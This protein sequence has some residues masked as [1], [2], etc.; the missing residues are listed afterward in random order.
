MLR[1][2]LWLLLGAV[3]GF[4]LARRQAG[5][6]EAAPLAEDPALELRRKLEE[7][8]ARE[9]PVEGGDV[10]ERRGQVHERGRSALDEMRRPPAP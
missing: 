9:G 8:K 6:G 10:E 3:A 4:F 7:A 1:R 2:L 5:S